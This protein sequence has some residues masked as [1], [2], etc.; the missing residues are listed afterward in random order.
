MRLFSTSKTSAT[1]TTTSIPLHS[2]FVPGGARAISWQKEFTGNH[3]VDDSQN[4]NQK[5]DSQSKFS[6]RYV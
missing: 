1:E 2:K 4:T 5:A 3:F 6:Q